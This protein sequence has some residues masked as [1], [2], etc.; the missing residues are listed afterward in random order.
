MG[1]YAVL[2][3]GTN[4]I[5]LLLAA[6]DDSGAAP[7]ER[8][9]WCAI[10]RL[11]E[12][13]AEAGG[14]KPGPMRRT[15]ETAAGFLAELRR[16]SRSGVGVAVAT[17]A[18]RDASNRAEFL[19]ACRVAL[20]WAPLVL[21]GEQEAEAAFLGAASDQSE[22]DLV[23]TV[24]VGGGST[25]LAAGLP[26][27][28][29]YRCSLDLGCVRF[30][31]RFGLYDS[32]APEAV[33]AA[34]QAV[35]GPAGAAVGALLAGIGGGG[36][37]WRVVAS[38]GTAT[39]YAAWRQGLEP[40]DRARVH[41]FRDRREVLADSAETLLH[42]PF[43]RRRRL[44]GISPERALVLPAGMLILAEVLAALG[45]AE[46]QVTTRGLRYGLVLQLQD[47]TVTGSW[48]W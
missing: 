26:G 25:E 38:G 42:I 8:T 16:H 29:L 5:L 21:S 6:E 4:S 22:G 2:D 9:E 46:F 39:T 40:Y 18:V 47:G 34:R 12:G 19:D 32:P 48:R 20:G 45:T 17:S 36:R 23:V 41:G 43:E 10:T 24:D 31:E 44:P 27:R 37:D 33:R 1:D 28:C 35:A 30:G 15:I 3:F 13:A 11:G 14:L 7:A